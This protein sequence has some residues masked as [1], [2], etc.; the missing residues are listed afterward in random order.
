VHARGR[1]PPCR[2]LV[3]VI[4]FDNPPGRSVGEQF[5]AVSGFFTG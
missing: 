2:H 5:G 4:H 1:A 3:F